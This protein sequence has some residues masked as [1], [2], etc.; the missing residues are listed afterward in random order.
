MLQIFR[1]WWVQVWTMYT[2]LLTF[3][4]QIT[5]TCTTIAVSMPGMCVCVCQSVY[6]C[7]CAFAFTKRVLRKMAHTSIERK[8]AKYFWKIIAH[9][10]MLT[11]NCKCP[12]YKFNWH[13]VKREL[14]YWWNRD[15]FC[16]DTPVNSITGMQCNMHAR[17]Y[18][19]TFC[20]KFIENFN[21][22]FRKFIFQIILFENK[23]NYK[24]REKN[25]TNQWMQPH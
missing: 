3:D 9:S 6:L 11:R 14:F 25:R 19:K 1:I 21:I 4:F 15:K 13:L 18:L 16:Q 7:F 23:P 12:S 10:E 20:F 22:L 2:S 8:L 24:C 5:R 17:I